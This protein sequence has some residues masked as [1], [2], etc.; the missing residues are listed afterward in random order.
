MSQNVTI[1]IW[2]MVW[3]GWNFHDVKIKLYWDYFG[4]HQHRLQKENA[5]LFCSHP[6][7]LFAVQG[8]EGATFQ[9]CSSRSKSFADRYWSKKQMSRQ[10]NTN[11]HHPHRS[12]SLL[13]KLE[14]PLVFFLVSFL[15]LQIHKYSQLL[16]GTT[17]LAEG[18]VD[19]PLSS[20]RGAPLAPAFIFSATALMS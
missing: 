2:Y 14:V 1:D 17:A 9:I 16:T 13:M 7:H 12:F 3:Q 5:F 20:C 15:T 11:I 10:K 19:W 4:N 8:E 6:L 18:A